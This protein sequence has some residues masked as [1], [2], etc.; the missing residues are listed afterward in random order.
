MPG[1]DILIRLLEVGMG[2]DNDPKVG[3]TAFG[4][5]HWVKG[6]PETTSRNM[7]SLSKI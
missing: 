4:G 6:Y 7:I 1:V 5:G 3:K 2:V